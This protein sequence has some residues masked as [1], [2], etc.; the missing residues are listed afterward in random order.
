[1]LN[2]TVVGTGT[3]D[4]EG[5]VTLSATAD[6]LTGEQQIDAQ[7]WLDRCGERYR[8]L[9]VDRSVVPPAPEGCARQPVEGLF[10]VRPVSSIVIDGGVVPP[11][12]RIRQGPAP[13]VWI[14]PSL[15][16]DPDFS[17]EWRPPSGLILAGAAG[18]GT[19]RDFSALACGNVAECDDNDRTAAFAATVGYWLSSYVG[20]EV[21]Y[22]RPRP[23][24]ARGSG[25]GF[26]FD[27]ELDGGLVAV[28]AKGGLPLGRV[29][30]TASLGGNFQRSTLTGNTTVEPTTVTIDEVEQE[31]PGGTH[32][33]QWRTEGWD[34]SYAGG[35][36]W[37]L[38]DAVAIY[39]EVGRHFLKGDDTRGSESRLDEAQTFILFGIRYRVF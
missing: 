18:L 11:T 1:V 31:I 28:A 19:L 4:A 12:L 16:D 23:A 26:E 2:T 8:V 6:G 15:A 36:E 9:V 33:L 39:G 35:A 37:W 17:S 29:R 10:V 38:S 22:F 34:F 20:A 21:T 13:A 5:I 25:T 7:V 27:T 14:R 24:T 32:T 3:A 30:L